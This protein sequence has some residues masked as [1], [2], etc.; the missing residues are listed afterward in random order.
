[1]NICKALVT[2]AAFFSFTL[3][4]AA[5]A[6]DNVLNL[7]DHKIPEK[8]MGRILA[9]EQEIP[10]SQSKGNNWGKNISVVTLRGKTN[11][12]GIDITQQTPEYID[13]WATVPGVKVWVPEYPETKDLDI[14]T[15]D[16]GW[17]TMHVVKY[18][19]EDLGFS[20]IYEKDG[21]VT[22][23]TNV[24]PVTD[25]DNLDLAIQYIDPFYYYV[26]MKP[27]VDAMIR[28]LTGGQIGFEN[29]MVITVGK[30]WA[31]MHNGD[32]PH[33]DPG[34]LAITTPQ[35]GIGPVYFNEAVAPD[36]TLTR[37][38]VDGGV[39]WFNVAVGQY[40]VTA[41]KDGVNYPT[42]TFDINADDVANGV[43]LYISSTPDSV[44]GD[45]DSPPGEY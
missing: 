18:K 15:D 8:L 32:L 30:S 10:G 45:N 5:Q 26:A 43:E 20:Y 14:Q 12:F 44:E 39:V 17:W 38:S 16:T 28:E 25:E 29:A 31:S 35:A 41:Q 33:G 6:Q 36:P 22:T 19:G 3:A 13:Y 21:W 7:T 42:I 24:I 37:T 34:A 1:M 40:Q 27:A 23:K 4:F 9:G 11:H 2:A